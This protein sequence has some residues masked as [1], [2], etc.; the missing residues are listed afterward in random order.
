MILCMT[1]GDFIDY[2]ADEVSAE[3]LYDDVFICVGYNVRQSG[4]YENVLNGQMF[5]IS[6]S[7]MSN[8]NPRDNIEITKR[9]YVL[10]YVSILDN[11]YRCKNMVAE[12]VLQGI[13]PGKHKNR[14]YIFIFDDDEAKK[15]KLPQCI[16]E[17]V[18][19][20]TGVPAMLYKKGK[21]KFYNEHHRD[22]IMYGLRDP[23]RIKKIHK[24]CDKCIDS[25]KAYRR[26]MWKNSAEERLR[27]TENMSMKELIEEVNELPEFFAEPLTKKNCPYSEE[28]LMDILA[29]YY[30]Q[31]VG[32][33]DADVMKHM[34]YLKDLLGL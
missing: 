25:Y 19:M 14:R 10:K 26:V 17:F 5:L 21:V 16:A 4:I 12:M 2:Y 32:V 23:K 8:I 18:Y 24:W 22:A 9:D 27:D 20:Q 34:T 7:D 3:Q 29:K 28:E 31:G 6:V 15:Y 30:G 33:S 11:D 1:I 13:T